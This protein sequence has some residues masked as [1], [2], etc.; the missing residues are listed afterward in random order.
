MDIATFEA[1]IAEDRYDE[2]AAV[3]GVKEKFYEKF[4]IKEATKESTD[5]QCAICIK[6]YK[7][8]D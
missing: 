2:Y 8:G 4:P 5:K 7:P 3:Y 1:I 6:Y